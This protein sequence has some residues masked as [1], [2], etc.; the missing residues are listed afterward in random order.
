LKN[1]LDTAVMPARLGLTTPDGPL[2]GALPTYRVYQARRGR[3]A[4]AALEPHFRKRLYVA[5]GL[6]DGHALDQVMLT[7]TAA[8]WQRWAERRDVPLTQVVDGRPPHIS[9]RATRLR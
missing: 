1:A 3:V 2:G 9:A 8:Q 5:L 7:K 4:V 6:P